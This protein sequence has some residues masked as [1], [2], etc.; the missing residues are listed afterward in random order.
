M[1]VLAINMMYVKFDS[2]KNITISKI[3]TGLNIIIL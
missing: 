1:T 2:L 3:E